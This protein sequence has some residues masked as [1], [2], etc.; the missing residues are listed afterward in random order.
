[1]GRQADGR[2]DVA[3]ALVGFPVRLALFAVPLWLAMRQE[4]A[5]GLA[6]AAAFIA[7]R[8]LLI[9]RVQ[10]ALAAAEEARA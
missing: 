4:L 7:V 8:A 9:R 1:M 2:G 5:V 10:R 6:F 3:L